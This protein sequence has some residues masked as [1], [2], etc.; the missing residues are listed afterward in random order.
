MDIQQARD[1]VYRAWADRQPFV[2]NT[3]GWHYCTCACNM[4][5]IV[6][7]ACPGGKGHAIG[8]GRCCE[9]PGARPVLVNDLWVCST[10]KLHVCNGGPSCNLKQGVCSIT[11]QPVQHVT[12]CADGDD[13]RA[14]CRRKKTSLYTNEQVACA[15]IYDL[16]FSNRRQVYEQRRYASCMEVS[17]RLCLRHIRD[18]CKNNKPIHMQSLISI[19]YENRDKLRSMLYMRDMSPEQ[20]KTTCTVYASKVVRFWSLISGLLD[21]QPCSFE[22]VTCAVLYMMRRGIAYDELMVIPP[23]R[24]LNKVLPDAHAIRDVGVQRRQFTQ[25][26]NNISNSIQSAIDT[27]RLHAVQI[28]ECFENVP[29]QMP[30]T[31]HYSK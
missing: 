25:V 20:Q 12:P 10:G 27:N 21:A 4:Q 6:A 1:I 28:A 22:T 18:R 2:L 30:D 7:W 26:K 31:S 9:H 29:S 23:D 5:H 15:F 11:Q 13:P 8:S 24:W 17:R 3:D 19:F 14:K 16:V